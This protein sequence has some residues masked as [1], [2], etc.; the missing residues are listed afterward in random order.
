MQHVWW[1][2]DLGRSDTMIAGGKG[3]N[4]AELTQGAF[5][6]PQASVA[7]RSR[8]DGCHRYPSRVSQ[9]DRSD[10]AKRTRVDLGHRAR[11]RTGTS[12]WSSQ[13]ACRGVERCLH[14]ALRPSG[15]DDI[16]V[17]VRS[18]A[19]RDR[20]APHLPACIARSPTSSAGSSWLRQCSHAGNHSGEIVP[21]PTGRPEI[22]EVPAIAVVV[23]RMLV[24]D[25]SG[26]AFTVD[27]SNGDANSI[28]IEGAYGQGEVVVS[29]QVEPDTY[30]VSREPRRVQHARR[31]SQMTAIVRGD[32]GADEVRELTAEQRATRVLTDSEVLDIAE[33]A[34]R[35]EAHYGGE[36]QD[37][38][39]AYEGDDLWIVQ[40]RPI[41]TFGQHPSSAVA[42]E[43]PERRQGLSWCGAWEQPPEWRA[44][45]SAF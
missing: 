13:H 31:G 34:C 18:S 21:L 19:T 22:E 40:T 29:G 36:P 35:I 45:A 41:T 1:F 11:S 15:G 5:S 6:G 25:R 30:V 8:G 10:L 9:A 14:E 24:V 33:V 38:E 26:V 4:L 28:V 43:E 32:D 23:Q 37:L 27:P 7:R 2:S 17:A 12:S 16:A 3:A 20:P 42:T 44:G 39:W